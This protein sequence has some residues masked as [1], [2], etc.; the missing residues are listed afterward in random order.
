VY[1]C[2]VGDYAE[3]CVYQGSGG[4]LNTQALPAMSPEFW[5]HRLG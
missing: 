3:A 5:A 1:N 4:A 2:V